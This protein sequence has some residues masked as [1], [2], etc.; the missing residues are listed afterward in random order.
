M[1][2]LF[3]LPLVALSACSAQAEDACVGEIEL[4][5]QER[6]SFVATQMEALKTLHSDAP[7]QRDTPPSP[8]EIALY[9]NFM[10]ALEATNNRIAV[11]MRDCPAFVRKAAEEGD[12]APV[13]D[14]PPAYLPIAEPMESE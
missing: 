14:M 5:R 2:A 6:D 11:R 7:A 3:A 4:L 1:R 10:S 8:E 13:V 12:A 9:S